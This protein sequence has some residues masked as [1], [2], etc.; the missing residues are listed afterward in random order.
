VRSF[1]TW[2]G[3]SS[4]DEPVGD[5][6][7]VVAVGQQ[8]DEDRLN[9]LAG[10][11]SIYN[12]TQSLDDILPL[13]IEILSPLINAEPVMPVGTIT[14]PSPPPHP[15]YFP[16]VTGDQKIAFVVP[17]GS[18]N[19]TLELAWRAQGDNGGFAVVNPAAAGV[20]LIR[21]K[22]H[23]LIVA[24]VFAV[25]GSTTASEWRLR[26]ISGGSAVAMT[27]DDVAA[28]ADLMLRAHPAFDQSHY[29]I[30]DAIDLSCSL[31]HGGL[32][33]ENATV[34]L[35]VARPGEGLGTF[36]STHAGR[37]KALER[38]LPSDIAKSPDRLSG[39]GLMHA[40]VLKVLGLDELPRVTPPGSTLAE[41]AP[42]DYAASF[43]DTAKEGTYIFRYRIEGT[44]PD[45]SRYSRVMVRS[46]WVGVRPDP[47]LLGAVWTP[48]QNPPGYLMTFTPKTASGEL[49]GPFRHDVI[50][51]RVIDGGFDGT[52]IDNLDGS[53]SRKIHTGAMG[54]NPVVTIDIYGFPM[55]PVGP[56]IDSP[57]LIG[58]TC[59]QLLLA[60][61]R[62]FLR[63]LAKLFGIWLRRP[64][65]IARHWWCVEDI[66]LD[67][68]PR[69]RRGTWA[70]GLAS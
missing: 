33:V 39:K 55:N 47:S 42:G 48:L 4:A 22:T 59:T 31:R 24:D 23:G 1:A 37:Y 53:Y 67:P 70:R 3:T 15:L 57:G 32:P 62:C 58:L 52:L 46:T 7:F 64:S 14:E 16:M 49:L 21:R 40:V 18:E 28:I 19:D 45:G 51:M 8:V 35:D 44:L 11:D 9:A 30:G 38:D 60:T 12:M 34:G 27:N 66:A 26:H 61:L 68:G 13:F 54:R 20:T 56:A 43:T 5:R 41:G 2:K 10:P 65:G 29:F 36:L 69:P 17:W 63:R 6:L 50:E 25:T